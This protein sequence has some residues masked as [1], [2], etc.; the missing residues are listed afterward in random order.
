MLGWVAA[1]FENVIY[2]PWKLI[3][4]GFKGAADGVGAG[5]SK[6]RMPFLAALFSPANA[7]VGFLTGAVEGVALSPGL[8]GP[9]DNFGYAMSR[10]TKHATTIWWYE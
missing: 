4:G 3:G 7:V 1:P 8:V 5:F 6:D 9:G 10:P 2:L